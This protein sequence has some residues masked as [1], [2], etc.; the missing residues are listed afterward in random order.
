MI[1][2]AQN[3]D[4]TS[5]GLVTNNEVLRLKKSFLRCR[6]LQRGINAQPIL[7]G[8]CG[9]YEWEMENEL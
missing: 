8:F 2:K 4:S 6:M 3:S 5:K 9:D 7:N 1:L